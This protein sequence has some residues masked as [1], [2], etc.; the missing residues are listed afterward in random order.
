[1]DY[2]SEPERGWVI[3]VSI[4]LSDERKNFYEAEMRKVLIELGGGLDIPDITASAVRGEWQGWDDLAYNV[5]P[6]SKEE[7]ARRSD[8]LK[9]GSVVLSFHGGGYISGSAAMERSATFKLAQLSGG[10]VFSIDYRIAP[11]SPFPAALIDAIVAYEYLIDPPPGAL[12][13]AIDPKNLII[14]GDSA[15]VIFSLLSIVDSRE[16]WRLL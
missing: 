3:P 5:G 16:V 12:H 15:G 9:N 8:D 14:A 11:Q 7:F 4:D 1:M 6:S 2:I 13:D 10:R